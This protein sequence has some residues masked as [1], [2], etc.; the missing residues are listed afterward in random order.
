LKIG[1]QENL[2]EE[3]VW[4]EV[5]NW[6]NS[7]LEEGY[8]LGDYAWEEMYEEYL[9]EVPMTGS[10]RPT[11]LSDPLANTGRAIGSAARSFVTG[12]SRP[13]NTGSQSTRAT[14]PSPGT[15]TGGGG[16]AAGRTTSSPVT[17]YRANDPRRTDTSTRSRFARP[18]NAGTPSTVAVRGTGGSS[19][20]RPPI[21]SLPASARQPTQYPAGVSTGVGGGNAGA[22]RPAPAAPARPVARPS[23]AAPRPAASAPAAAP[24]PV[25]RPSAAPAPSVPRSATSAPAAAPRP[26]ASA[27]S[28][29]KSTS[30][31]PSTSPAATTG[32]PPLAPKPLP[33]IM[34]KPSLSS[35]AA[36]I[37]A[38]RQRSQQ[39][40]I[41]QGG[42][43]ATA[44]VQSFDPF[45]VVL[46]HL[47]D[48]GYA[49]TEES[50]LQIMANMSEEWRDGILDEA[51]TVMSVTSPS[52]KSRR[53][54]ISKAKPSENLE[55]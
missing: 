24:R 20:Q 55:G 12:S 53:L 8:D 10:N 52:E 19:T 15:S 48:E 33:P 6:V 40:I 38:M 50:A 39:R 5:E 34:G 1:P 13:G 32:N 44:L 30:Q 31:A 36:E 2:N 16:Y 47:I 29:S 51:K 7:L 45:D 54:N 41:S 23:A 27:P 3:L 37:R 26:A 43:P 21:G 35:Q 22:S 14:Q 9:S 28:I 49:D 11:K 4:E 18:M 17:P 25:A 42:T 46:G